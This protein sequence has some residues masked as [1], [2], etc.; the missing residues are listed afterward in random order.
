MAEATETKKDEKPKAE[1]KPPKPP[2]QQQRPE[3]TEKEATQRAVAAL[4]APSEWRLEPKKDHVLV[5]S[6]YPTYELILRPRKFTQGMN[7]EKKIVD[8]ETQ[9]RIKLQFSAHKCYLPRNLLEKLVSKPFY[10]IDFVP[11]IELA[12]ALDNKHQ[13][14]GFTLQMSAKG[15]EA[16]IGQMVRRSELTK[17]VGLKQFTVLKE[18][19]RMAEDAEL[20]K[21]IEAA[22]SV[23]HETSKASTGVVYSA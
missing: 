3:R 16:F 1:G 21:E 13:K 17:G 22:K 4:A 7:D 2:K 18:L 23:H 19:M 14:R 10:G 6:T 20:L 12:A 9:R 15:A 5:L 8:V 11:A